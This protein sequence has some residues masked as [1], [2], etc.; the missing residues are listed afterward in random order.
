MSAQAALTVWHLTEPSPERIRAFLAR[1]AGE[2]FSYPSVGATRPGPVEP[3]AP[4]GFDLDHN[5][6]FLGDGPGIFEAACEALARWEMFP[7][8]WA[9]IEAGLEPS[10]G[11]VPNVAPPPLREGTVVAMVARALGVWWLSACRIVYTLD[12]RFESGPV[13][14]RYGFAYGTLPG[15]VERGEERFSVELLEDGTAW[16][17]LLAFSTPRYWMVRLGYPVARRL[18]RRFVLDSLAAMRRA[19]AE[20]RR[21]ELR[22]AGAATS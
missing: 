5:R 11:P 21:T 2:P 6:T 22:K 14:R 18:Q 1:Q 17:D 4:P 20:A 9:R 8:A 19:A 3:S 13:R 7:A 16:Y 10:G 15:H 12:E